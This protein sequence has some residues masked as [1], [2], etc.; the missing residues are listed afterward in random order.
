MTPKKTLLLVEDE[1]L[2]RHDLRDRTAGKLPAAR[3]NLS[4]TCQWSIL[5]VTAPPNGRRKVSPTV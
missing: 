4:R 1:G 5:A 3:E 2:V